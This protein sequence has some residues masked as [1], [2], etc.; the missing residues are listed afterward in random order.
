MQ[1]LSKTHYVY[2]DAGVCVCG[3]GQDDVRVSSVFT[4][5]RLPPIVQECSQNIP[6]TRAAI[7][8]LLNPLEPVVTRPNAHSPSGRQSSAV[9]HVPLCFYSLV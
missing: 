7:L 6:D 4:Q 1:D 2:K 8:H 5:N 3:C 9:T